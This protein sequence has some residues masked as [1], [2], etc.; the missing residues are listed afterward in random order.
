M[1]EIIMYTRLSRV[2][3]DAL[4]I[5]ELNPDVKSIT[6]VVPFNSLLLLG[7]LG[8][9]VECTFRGMKIK[10]THK[11][12]EGDNKL[13][14]LCKDYPHFPDELINV[15][16]ERL[17]DT[18]IHNIVNIIWDLRCLYL[19]PHPEQVYSFWEDEVV[20]SIPLRDFDN[21][22]DVIDLIKD[23]QLLYIYIGKTYSPNYMFK[24]KELS[25]VGDDL[26]IVKG[27]EYNDVESF[28]VKKNTQEFID[29]VN[30]RK[31]NYQVYRAL[32]CNPDN[33]KNIIDAVE[34]L[35]FRKNLI[36]NAK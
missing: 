21:A 29:L 34:C 10:F 36:D 19:G 33:V 31:G 26:V 9:K 3:Q 30:E 20:Y 24:L 35:Y 6:A 18:V 1:T 16:Y 13:K 15:E 5:K 8:D 32:E 11:A 4:N 12:P 17:G 23:S 28:V 2:A 14:Y 7:V 22:D 27:V 25:D